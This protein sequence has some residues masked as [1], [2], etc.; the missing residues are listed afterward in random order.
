[1]VDVIIVTKLLQL[2][3]LFEGYNTKHGYIC[4]VFEFSHLFEALKI[5][6]FTVFLALN[7]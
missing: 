2:L 6:V 1:M 3:Q 7:L 5:L 4:Q